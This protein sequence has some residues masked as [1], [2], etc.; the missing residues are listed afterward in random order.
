MMPLIIASIAFISMLT[1]NILNVYSSKRRGIKDS[2]KFAIKYLPIQVIGYFG[3]VL[4]YVF[5]FQSFN[6]QYWPVSLMVVLSNYST[7]L[8]A[9]YA[10]LKQIP[11]KGQII[12]L[13]LIFIGALTALFIT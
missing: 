8:V 5:G 12:G 4:V 1:M 13:T 2:L 9:G 6:N 10:V 7:N 3:I 11:T